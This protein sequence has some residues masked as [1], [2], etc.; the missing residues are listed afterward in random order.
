[1][2]K[3]LE[4]KLEEIKQLGSYDV[5]LYYG[6]SV[7]CDDSEVERRKR[8]VRIIFYPVGVLGEA[9]IMFFGTL[10]NFLNFDL[11]TKPNVISNPPKEEYEAGGYFIWGVEKSVENVLEKPFHGQ[12]TE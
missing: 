9:R 11:K 1:M 5:T 10:G 4:D 7:G 2:S 8:N 3:S 6:E 12:W